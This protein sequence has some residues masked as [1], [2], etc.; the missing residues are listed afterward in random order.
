MGY[1]MIYALMNL[2]LVVI[3]ALSAWIRLGVQDILD[4]HNLTAHACTETLNFA[5][6]MT[7]GPAFSPRTASIERDAA[8]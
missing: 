8:V 4:R 5:T 2:G 7:G 3:G 1:A 6:G